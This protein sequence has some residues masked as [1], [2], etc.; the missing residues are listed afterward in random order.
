MLFNSDHQERMNILCNTSIS[1]TAHVSGVVVNLTV[2]RVRVCM[3]C[4]DGEKTTVNQLRKL[5]LKQ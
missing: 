3:K 5:A 4:S 2:S 1:K